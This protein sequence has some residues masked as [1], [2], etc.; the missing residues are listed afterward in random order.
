MLTLPEI[1]EKLR[2]LRQQIADGSSTYVNVTSGIIY[3]WLREGMPQH[4]PDPDNQP[5]PRF[6]GMTQQ[7]GA[8]AV[9]MVDDVWQ[10]MQQAE[11]ALDKVESLCKPILGVTK[12]V[13]QNALERANRCLAGKSIILR[14]VHR[15]HGFQKLTGLSCGPSESISISPEKLIVAM[16]EAA[17]KSEKVFNNIDGLLLSLNGELLT[18]SKNLELIRELG[19][20]LGFDNMPELVVMQQKLS[21]LDQQVHDDPLLVKQQL[22]NYIS[23]ILQR[24]QTRLETYRQQRDDVATALAAGNKAL[25]QLQQAHQESAKSVRRCMRQMA[26]RTAIHM[27][28]E[29]KDLKEAVDWLARL[30]D[31][32]KEGHWKAVEIGLLSWNA[33]LKEDLEFAQAVLRHN[34][35]LLDSGDNLRGLLR[36]M[37]ARAEDRGLQDDQ[38]LQSLAREAREL[39]LAR[40]LNVKRAQLM[41]DAYQLKLREKLG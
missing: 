35:N 37:E 34:S 8:D 28:L 18:A 26:D 25:A 4:N 29:E 3:R 15:A 7:E 22:K 38:E 1:E 30:E 27:P 6:K 24:L 20:S 32:F 5:P 23:P 17:S 11:D 21:A 2:D 13:S 9:A 10:Y 12:W 31:A 39:L 19:R 33:Q 40:P 41:V 36:A 16:T 14:D